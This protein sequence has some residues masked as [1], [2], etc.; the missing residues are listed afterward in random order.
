MKTIIALSFVSCFIAYSQTSFIFPFTTGSQWQFTVTTSD[1]SGSPGVVTLT[2]G[3]DSLLPNHKLYKGYFL[4]QVVD[5]FL[6]VEGSKVYQYW[7][8]DSTEFV[9]YDFTKHLGDTVDFVRWPTYSLPN[10]IIKDTLLNVFGKVR[11]MIAVRNM[12]GYYWDA[13]LDSIGIYGLW[14]GMDYSWALAGAQIAGTL[15][16]H[17][18]S[19]DRSAED[20]PTRIRLDLN[21]PNPFKSSTIIRYEVKEYAGVQ[22]VITDQLGRQVQRLVNSLQSPGVHQVNWDASRFASGVYFCTMASGSYRKSIK[23]VVLK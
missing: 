7:F 1:P 23:L 8:W 9:R 11:R 16:G 18:T 12:A 2:L 6:R 15:Y 20:V 19:V 4:G 21:Y 17:I 13:V 22:I 3:P 14:D 10:V 5:F